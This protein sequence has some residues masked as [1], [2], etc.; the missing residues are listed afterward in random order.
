MTD[1]EFEEWEREYKDTSMSIKKIVKIIVIGTIV[2]VMT[3][4]IMLTR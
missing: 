2:L 1:K 4:L 3:Y